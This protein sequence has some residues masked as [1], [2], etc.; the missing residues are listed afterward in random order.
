MAP[1][2][3]AAQKVNEVNVEEFF[4][5]DV[6]GNARAGL[7]LDKNG[8]VGLVMGIESWLFRQTIDLL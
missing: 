6:D 5:L 8:E 4:L 3:V 2:R 7:G 1:S